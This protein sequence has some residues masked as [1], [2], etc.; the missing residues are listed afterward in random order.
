MRTRPV[1]WLV[2]VAVTLVGGCFL[3]VA[4]L[5]PRHASPDADRNAPLVVG[6]VLSAIGLWGLRSCFRNRHGTPL[7][8]AQIAAGWN[9][10][11]RV[12]LA[13]ILASLAM[14]GA[15]LS[16]MLHPDSVPTSVA[17]FGNRPFGLPL[18]LFVVLFFTLLSV[19]L[20]F[21]VWHAYR[22][23]FRGASEGI[24]FS[25]H[26]II[27]SLLRTPSFHPDLRRSR[28]IV[29]GVGT[30]YLLLMFGWIA[31]AAVRGI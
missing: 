28:Y 10:P 27:R 14:Y 5:G 30:F 29:L 16:A 25:K 18:P 7:N 13:T 1:D 6:S 23:L 9:D 19:P 4:A 15:V 31:Y 22:I 24:G 11:K 20:P 21:G 2:C 12:R 17:V 26:E 3:L 8:P